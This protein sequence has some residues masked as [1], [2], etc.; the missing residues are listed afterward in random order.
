MKIKYS[1]PL[2]WQMAGRVIVEVEVDDEI[3][4]GPDSEKEA[5]EIALGPECSLPNGD[6]LCDSA[7]VDEESGIEIIEE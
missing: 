1:I 4:P 7:E 6:Y 3:G 2:V 5:K